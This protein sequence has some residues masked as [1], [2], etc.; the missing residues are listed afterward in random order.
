VAETKAERSQRAEEVLE[1]LGQA[2]PEAK[3]ELDHGTDWELLVAVVLSAQSTDR[4][5][6]R[7]T[8]DLHKAFPSIE[9]FARVGPK[10]IEPHI[11][12]LGLFRN[13]AKSLAAL[14][15]TLIEA[16][17]GAVP[18]S[19]AA[20][21]MLPGVGNKTAGV[22]SMHIG[23]DRA[24]PVDTHVMR[25][26][27]RLGFTRA[28]KPDDVEADMQKLLPSEHWFMGHQLLVWHGRR[29]CHAIKPECHRCVVKDL[30]PKRGVKKEKKKAPVRA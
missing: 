3:I 17:G 1:L 15:R 23:G 24:F 6:N 18:K 22:V 16:H 4:G 10:E 5:V 14:A 12:T 27:Y 20:L 13:K 21:A 7:V 2:M 30:C 25:L 19:R 26:A 9:A 28:Q 29:V 11:K 8:P